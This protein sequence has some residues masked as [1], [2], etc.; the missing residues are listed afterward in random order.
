MYTEYVTIECDPNSKLY[1]G[2]V[3]LLYS[4]HQNIIRQLCLMV[5]SK[6]EVRFGGENLLGS[7][8]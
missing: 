6:G 7:V 5:T 2:S 1:S 3:V 8:M 4:G